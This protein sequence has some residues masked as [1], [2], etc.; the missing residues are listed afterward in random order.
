MHLVLKRRRFKLGLFIVRRVSNPYRQFVVGRI[1][2]VV[3]VGWIC[4][5]RRWKLWAQDASRLD[6]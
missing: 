3:G 6:P 2:V 1:V 5:H 4:R